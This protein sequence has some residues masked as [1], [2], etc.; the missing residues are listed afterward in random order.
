[1]NEDLERLIK[2]LKGEKKTAA[3]AGG[4]RDVC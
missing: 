1:M 2:E 4:W 3:A